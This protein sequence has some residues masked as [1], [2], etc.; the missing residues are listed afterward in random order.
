EPFRT[1]RSERQ[2]GHLGQASIADTS[3][4]DG[5]ISQRGA[6]PKKISSLSDSSQSSYRYEKRRLREKI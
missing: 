4:K 3:L 2:F 5:L 1:V 6:C